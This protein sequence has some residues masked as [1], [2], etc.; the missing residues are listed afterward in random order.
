VKA[1]PLIRAS[2]LDPFVNVLTALGSPI[3]ALF[4]QAKLPRDILETPNALIPE[5]SVWALLEKSA[6]H[7]G[8]EGFGFLC[9]VQG[10][11]TEIGDIR[12]WLASSPT[13]YDALRNFCRLVQEHSSQSNF[14]LSEFASE[15]WFCREGIKE[16]NIG[17]W[18]VEQYA[19]TIMVQLIRLAAGPDW[20]PGKIRLQTDEVGG[21]NETDLL[22]D[23]ELYVAQPNTCIAI[24]KA[25]LSQPLIESAHLPPVNLSAKTTMQTPNELV[26]DFVGSLRELLK[27][28]LSKEDLQIESIAEIIGTS[29]RT[30]QR[31][32][33]EKGTSFSEV[34]SQTRFIIAKDQLEN[35]DQKIIDIAYELGYQDPAHFSRAFYRWAGIS[36]RQ[37]RSH[38]H[39]SVE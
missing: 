34:V 22:N 10:A 8:I 31:R 4:T 26:R 36:P 21:I 13:L 24:P 7:E 3:Q 6:N 5:R 14:W 27:G 1:I 25:L 18:Q 15:T 19:L 33:N 9:G 12:N 16:I 28:Y 20:R 2:Q 23:A 17:R 29:K 39:T 37:F 35:G 32:L 30:L 11:V 38:L